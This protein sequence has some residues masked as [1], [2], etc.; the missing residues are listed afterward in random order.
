[1]QQTVSVLLKL[2]DSFSVPG[3]SAGRSLMSMGKTLMYLNQAAELAARAMRVVGAAVKS[4]A[5]Q[6]IRAV[7]QY[8]TVE[9]GIGGALAAFELVPDFAAGRDAAA[10]VYKDLERLAAPLPG[11]VDDFVQVFQT[12]LPLAMDAFAEKGKGSLRDIANFT[13]RFSAVAIANGVEAIQVASDL[14]RLVGGSAGIMLPTFR[15][16]LPLIK[17]AG[18]DIGLTISGAEQLNKLT[19]GQRLMILQRVIALSGGAIDA[20]ESTID[21]AEGTIESYTAAM[22]RA[23]GAPIYQAYVSGL[24]RVVG[25]LGGSERALTGAFVGFGRLV[26]GAMNMAVSAAEQVGRTLAGIPLLRSLLAVMAGGG[27]GG[28]G[29]TLSG[30]GQMAFTGALAALEGT[31]QSIAGV[32][33]LL[34]PIVAAVTAVLAPIVAVFLMIHSAVGAFI[35]TLADVALPVLGFVFS[36]VAVLFN[37]LLPVFKAMYAAGQQLGKGLAQLVGPVVGVLGLALGGL[38]EVLKFVLVPAFSLVAIAVRGLADG[39]EAVVN[40]L[41]SYIPGMKAVSFGGGKSLSDMFASLV[42]AG[43]GISAGAESMITRDLFGGPATA[44]AAAAGRAKVPK[45]RGGTN[46][47]FRYSRFDITQQFAEGFDPD[48]IAVAF[49]DD[50]SKLGEMRAQSNLAPVFALR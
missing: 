37:E 7:S 44:G 1:M 25:A 47:D 43:S 42:P 23:G 26:A 28:V 3:R 48:R 2:V 12:T 46:Y 33:A 34:A 10:A 50:L 40:W 6:M 22:M 4:T 20:F 32:F 16:L 31:V 14:P 5:G 24:Q 9:I 19:A 49:A 15:K 30:M 36:R 41:A 38:V 17:K 29:A 21:A 39:I 27:A 35:G 45:K 8:K 18:A 13:S 11:S